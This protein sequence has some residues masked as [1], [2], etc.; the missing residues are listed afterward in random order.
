MYYIVSISNVFFTLITV[1]FTV[2]YTLKYILVSSVWIVFF[3][4]HFETCSASASQCWDRATM[5]GLNSLSFRV[6]FS[7]CS[8]RSSLSVYDGQLYGVG[9]FLWS[10]CGFRDWT[11]VSKASTLP[12]KL[13]DWPSLWFFLHNLTMLPW[14][15]L[16]SWLSYNTT[17]NGWFIDFHFSC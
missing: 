15:V 5:S 11:Q 2:L 1:Y 16:N 10:L 9:Y 17:L 12:I 14:L 4:I 7:L 3:L 8:N 6:S 13:S